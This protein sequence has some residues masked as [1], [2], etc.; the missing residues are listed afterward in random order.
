MLVL[1]VTW[2]A[3]EGE[4]DTVIQLF[5]VLAETSLKEP[6][7]RAFMVHRGVEDPRQFM[8]YEQY[9]DQA[10]LDAHRAAPYFKEIARGALLKCAE[11]R[12]GV[13]YIRID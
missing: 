4:E 1:A 2:V 8:I 10:S 7:C 6:G 12:E 13:L 11:R 9:R 5:R 3:K